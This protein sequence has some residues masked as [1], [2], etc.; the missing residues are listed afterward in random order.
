MRSLK[1]LV[2]FKI[3]GKSG[4]PVREKLEKEFLARGFRVD[5]ISKTSK[6]G[7]KKYLEGNKDCS[8]VLL[9]QFIG[10]GKYD[11]N[12]LAELTDRRFVNVVVVLE[13]RARKQTDFLLTI[14]AAG[15][16]SAFF[17]E[18]SCG[19][20]YG[21][22][23]EMLLHPRAR[24]KAR[25]Y[26][27][28]NTDAVL[29]RSLTLEAFSENLA[30]L[31]DEGEGICPMNRLLHIA[32]RLNPYQMADFLDKLPGEI[33]SPL[34]KYAEFGQLVEEMRKSGV[35]V[36][37]YRKPW[38]YRYMQDEYPLPGRSGGMAGHEAGAPH[39]D[40][41]ALPDEAESAES[42]PVSPEPE[43]EKGAAPDGGFI[44]FK[45]YEEAAEDSGGVDRADGIGLGRYADYFD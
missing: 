21:E 45:D 30:Y 10:S 13:G 5:L 7:V 1:V 14:Y 17:Q 34:M 43:E 31:R 6:Q 18:G 22:V 39:G 29:V 44:D 3:T 25:E 36:R 15:I 12:E 8:H 23:V 16:T 2:D 42:G 33:V 37:H 41:F 20:Q 9:T 32:G 35:K 40:A 11:E 38:R 27:G 24:E 19:P 28:I 26:Y 4:D